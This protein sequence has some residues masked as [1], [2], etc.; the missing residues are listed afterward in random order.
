VLACRALGHRYRFRADGATMT[1]ACARC[2]AVGGEKTYAS[3]AE[4]EHFARAFDHEDRSELGRRAPLVGLLPL[5]L[6]RAW[7]DRKG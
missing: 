1:W 3:A 4:A 6:W 7:R 2:G 5:R